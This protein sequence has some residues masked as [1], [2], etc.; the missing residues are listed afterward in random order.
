MFNPFDGA[1]YLTGTILFSALGIIAGTNPL[2][3]LAAPFITGIFMV[4][5]KVL[6]L[7]WKSRTEK[8]VARLRERA[9]RAE[10]DVIRLLEQNQN[11]IAG[12]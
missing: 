1:N 12:R 2:L 4:L 6:E 9:E 11:D 10:A 3:L 5:C 8:R 7:L